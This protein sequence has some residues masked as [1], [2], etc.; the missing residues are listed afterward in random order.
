MASPDD[1]E[2]A[3]NSGR[4]QHM[5][6]AKKLAPPL[7]PLPSPLWP[8][9]PAAKIENPDKMFMLRGNHELRDVNGWIE[10]YGERSFLWQC[11]VRGMLVQQQMGTDRWV[12]VHY[13][14]NCH[15]HIHAWTGT[16]DMKL[17][18]VHVCPDRD[19]SYGRW[20]F[21]RYATS[22]KPNNFIGQGLCASG[23]VARHT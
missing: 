9:R 12:G 6:Q 4:T 10:H 19:I 5:Q 21:C 15:G 3:R 8:P 20:R 23:M 18:W 16:Y 7:H 11:Q 1:A 22:M 14:R 17:S 2:R 13:A